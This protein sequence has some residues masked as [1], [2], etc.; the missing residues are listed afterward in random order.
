MS[1]ITYPSRWKTVS[2]TIDEREIEAD[3]ALVGMMYRKSTGPRQ[4]YYEALLFA[5]E[6]YS[7]KF[8]TVT[9]LEAWIIQTLGAVR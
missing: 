4:G 8:T 9:R 1:T 7:P 2:A 5:S 3:G 6:T